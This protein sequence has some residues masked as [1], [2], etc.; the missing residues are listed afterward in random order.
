MKKSGD[1]IDFDWEHLSADA[2]IRDEQLETIASVMLALRSGLNRAGL[3]DKLIGYTTR[4]NAFWDDSSRP[5]GVTTFSSDG[6]GIQIDKYLKGKGS[7]MKQVVDFANIML[8]DVPPE[9]LGAPG[10]LRIQQFREVF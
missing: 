3:N 6:E 5:S 8:Y 7:S 4:F 1:G 2:S 10:G 9:Q